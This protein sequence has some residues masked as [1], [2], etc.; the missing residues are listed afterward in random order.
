MQR[1]GARCSTG[2]RL[3][4]RPR[5]MQRAT[6]PERPSAAA[7]RRLTLSP[8]P[9]RRPRP[10]PDL[11][12]RL[13]QA[14]PSSPRTARELRNAPARRREQRRAGPG[15]AARPP[16]SAF[17]PPASPAQI[18]ARGQLGPGR[19]RG[20]APHTGPPRQRGPT[21]CGS[22]RMATRHRPQAPRSRPLAPRRPVGPQ[23][24]QSEPQQKRRR[25][26]PGRGPRAAAKAQPQAW[27]W[28]LPVRWPPSKLQGSPWMMR[29]K[30]ASAGF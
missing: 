25:R 30:G 11:R 14:Q 17:W 19:L 28:R 26:P 9:P 29:L 4:P 27:N 15:R 21:E 20:P 24:A 5:P 3:A 12:R 1:A 8:A 23:A 16:A 2:A 7:A 13:Q 22:S 10:A 18:R 6:A